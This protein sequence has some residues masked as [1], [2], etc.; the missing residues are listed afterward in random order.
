[1]HTHM[2]K[3]YVHMSLGRG[4]SWGS[5]RVSHG[6]AAMLCSLDSCIAAFGRR[7]C[8]SGLEKH[9]LKQTLLPAETL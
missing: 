6:T 8:L 4:G 3:H 2:C 1:M 5:L 9:A 7:G